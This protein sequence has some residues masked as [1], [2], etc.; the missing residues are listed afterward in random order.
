MIS[1]PS[2]EEA[3][4]LMKRTQ[5]ALQVHGNLRLHKFA[6]S[7]KDVMTAL[8]A[9][10]LNKDLNDLELSSDELPLQR[11]L[12]LYWNINTD[13]FTFRIS[14]EAKPLT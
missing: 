5:E 14:Q 2:P 7:C 10:D 4:D 3:I 13:V 11:S 8:P 6:S 1:L 9:N 12:G